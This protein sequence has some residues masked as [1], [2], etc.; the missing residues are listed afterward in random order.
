MWRFFQTFV[1]GT[2]AILFMKVFVGS[3]PLAAVSAAGI[4]IWYSWG[5]YSR[6]AVSRGTDVIDSVYYLGF[7][8][9]LVSL[10][11]SLITAGLVGAGLLDTGSIV[12]D[13][14]IAITSTMAGMLCRISLTIRRDGS[15]EGV[16][17]EVRVS[18]HEAAMQ[19]QTQFRY[20]IADFE[21]FRDQL[22]SNY[23]EHADS[24]GKFASA[25]EKSTRAAQERAE[26]VGALATK[27]LDVRKDI[28]ETVRVFIAELK[29]TY[30]SVEERTG[31][32]R[33]TSERLQVFV[34]TTR[35]VG[36][37]WEEE[38][39]QIEAM[40]FSAAKVMEAAVERIR[41]IDLAA[42]IRRTLDASDAWKTAGTRGREE[43]KELRRLAGEMAVTLEEIRKSNA[44]LVEQAKHGQEPNRRDKLASGSPEGFPDPPPR[45]RSS[46]IARPAGVSFF[47]D[48]PSR[49]ETRHWDAPKHPSAKA[50]PK[51]SPDH[52]DTS[53][54][55]VTA[56]E[57][58]AENEAHRLSSTVIAQQGENA[59][60]ADRDQ[61]NFV[62][63]GILIAA[64]AVLLA[65]LAVNLP[66]WWAARWGS[67]GP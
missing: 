5:I 53:D 21:E 39:G 36:Q 18:L 54:E 63:R 26:H 48:E 65:A 42:E 1:G 62:F 66:G 9:T 31:L 29:K 41:K 56:L 20:A 33:E 44:T 6:P 27:S 32:I 45:E 46:P 49:D 67:S 61:S 37:Q 50:A 4:I 24:I 57:K 55:Y 58:W 25:M 51:P 40:T 13:F 17:D 59:M 22:R 12:T 11:L 14:G 64:V 34:D 3:G 47:Q 38:A 2:V 8:F 7:L 35:T 23:K 16:D 43:I 28:E 19:L 30:A 15:A 60:K 52:Y 10:C